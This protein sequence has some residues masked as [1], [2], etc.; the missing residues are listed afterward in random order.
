VKSARTPRL[1]IH[2]QVDPVF[3]SKVKRTSLRQAVQA[4]FAAAGRDA[5]GE[6]T[7][8]VTDDTRVKELNRTYRDV[9]ATTDVLAFGNLD[10]AGTVVLSPEDSLYWGDIVI[11]YPRAVEQAA[12]YGHS[13]E[14]EL[15]VLVVHGVLHLLGHDHQ[16]AADDVGMWR[17]QADALLQIG[18]HWQ[19]SGPPPVEGQQR[20][21]G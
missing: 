5:H 14:E 21:L 17:V 4:A 12:E 2:L 10:E 15:S 20:G 13:A 9:D 18:I 1:G 3:R 19:P 7:V 6:L 8:V 11:S 16:G